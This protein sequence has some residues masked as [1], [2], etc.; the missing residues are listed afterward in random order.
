MLFRSWAHVRGACIRRGSSRVNVLEAQ[1]IA[2]WIAER[3]KGRHGWLAHYEGQ[4]QKLDAIHK[5]VAVV[6]PFGAQEAAIRSALRLKGPDFERIT[7]GTVHKLQ[8]ADSPII[9]F[10]PTYS[11]DSNLPNTM[12]FDNKPCLTLQC[13]ARKTVLL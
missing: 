7:V 12:F 4:P 5:I 6:T 11:A 8:G 13:P 1:S 10:S 3:A 9:I 2:D